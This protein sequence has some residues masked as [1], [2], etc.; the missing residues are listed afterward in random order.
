MFGAY[1]LVDGISAITAGARAGRRGDRWGWLV[2]EGIVG[3]AAGILT[4]FVPQLTAVALL[5]FIAFWAIITGIAE[6]AQAIRLR[7]LVKGEW[8]LGLAGVLSIVL[9]ILLFASP[10]AGALA[11]VW[12]IGIYAIIF[13][14][15]MLSLAF[16]LR[17]WARRHAPPWPAAGVP[18][19]V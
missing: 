19:P 1:A 11:L 15:L 2:F 13:G 16:R 18:S 12:V 10:G 14:V 8:M 4:F 3:V 17:S 6:I 9:G 5:F 7:K